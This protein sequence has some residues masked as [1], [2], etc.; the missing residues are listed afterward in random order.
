[1]TW[2]L[3]VED[4]QLQLGKRE[5]ELAQAMMRIN[6]E[7]AAKAKAQKTLSEVEAQMSELQEDLDS[8]KS[9]RVEAEK[10]KHDLNE[11]LEAL[12]NELLGS[13]DSTAAQQVT[14]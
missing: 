5:E 1:M 7:G 10:Q 8:E 2:T 4:L 6:E 11:E 13:L 12:K 9:A 3:Q 14:H